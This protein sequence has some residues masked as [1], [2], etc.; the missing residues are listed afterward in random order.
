MKTGADSPLVTIGVIVYNEEPFIRET[1]DSLLAQDYPNFEL[2]VADNC[3]TD[4]SGTICEQIAK[5]DERVRYV[6]HPDNIG[7]AANSIFVLEEAAGD[8]FM[9]AAGHDLWSP[10]LLRRC[11]EA[12]EDNPEAVIA[13]AE[14]HWI[15]A[16]GRPLPRQS[17]GYDT[18]GLSPVRRY[19]MAFWGNMHPVLGVMRTRFLRQVPRIHRGVGADQVLLTEL[20]LRGD[21]IQVPGT[22]W[23]RRQPRDPETHKQRMRRYTGDEFRLSG[24]WLDRHLPLLRLPIEQLRSIARSELG[25]LEK[26]VVM[27]SLFPAFVVRYL[28]GR[29]S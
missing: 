24:N 27:L 5:D 12:L 25:L 6:R 11:V 10:D 28:D 3:S 16:D 4:D 22:S 20:A 8:Y 17:G 26:I 14:S 29:K 7:S 2:I 23:S 19:F 9:W 1:L 15:D 18:R 13:C 21:F